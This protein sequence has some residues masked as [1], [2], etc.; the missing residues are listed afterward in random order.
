MGDSGEFDPEIYT[1]IAKRYP[2]Q[3]KA[4]FIRR[5]PQPKRKKIF[6]MPK[7]VLC[8]DKQKSKSPALAPTPLSLSQP[9]NDHLPSSDTPVGTLTTSAEEFLTEN[10]GSFI[11]KNPEEEKNTNESIFLDLK[12]TKVMS[13][14]SSSSASSSVIQNELSSK[15]EDARFANLQKGLASHIVFRVFDV[16]SDLFRFRIENS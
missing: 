2:E 14:G 5:A 6:Q 11:E 4:I 1:E 9:T 12:E 3:V 7:N 8:F 13:E 10:V 16:G 15:E